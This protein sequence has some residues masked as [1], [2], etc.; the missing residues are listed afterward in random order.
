[1]SGVMF[2]LGPCYRCG[3]LFL[4]N[5]DRVPSITVHGTRE[6]FCL[7]CI[8][9]VNPGQHRAGASRDHPAPGRV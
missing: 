7:A 3:Q 2:V 5:A 6:P 8:T 9:A 1:M 4:F